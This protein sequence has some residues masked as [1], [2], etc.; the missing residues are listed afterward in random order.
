MPL[1]VLSVAP[2]AERRPAPGTWRRGGPSTGPR[3]AGRRGRVAVAAPGDGFRAVPCRLRHAAQP[4]CRP[5]GQR[6]RFQIRIGRTVHRT[7]A[8]A[9][10][11]ARCCWC[12]CARRCAA[13]TDRRARRQSVR[14]RCGRV[15]GARGGHGRRRSSSPASGA[16]G[17]RQIERCP[18]SGRR[19]GAHSGTGR[20]SSR[21]ACHAY[22]S[23][24]TTG[25]PSA[26]LGV[27]RGQQNILC[28]RGDSECG[29]NHL[30][31]PIPLRTA[32][33]RFERRSRGQQ[34]LCG[35]RARARKRTHAVQEEA[36]KQPEI[37][38]YAACGAPANYR[39]WA[40][41][42]PHRSPAPGRIAGECGRPPQFAR[43]LQ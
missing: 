38:T 22:T 14:A 31:L 27:L 37:S 4:A 28:T 43:I 11:A 5:P 7:C 26:L 13:R 41:C 2:G 35:A 29:K 9:H 12:G 25:T 32:A 18:A 6:G 21:V 23:T 20:R 39:E 17:V 36:R 19:N 40:S 33:G 3:P 24:A 1:A 16:T 10:P 15:S 8:A 42:G 30:L 34:F